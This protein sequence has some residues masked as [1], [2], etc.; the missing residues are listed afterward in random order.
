MESELGKSMNVVSVTDDGPAADKE[1][2]ERDGLVQLVKL[3]AREV[4]ALK[5]EINML[6][7]KGGHIYTPTLPSNS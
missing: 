7:H 6:R 5:S 1:K 2:S 4:D 3:Q